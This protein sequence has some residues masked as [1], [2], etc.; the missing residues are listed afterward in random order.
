MCRCKGWPVGTLDIIFVRSLSQ[1]SF[2]A[3]PCAMHGLIHVMCMYTHIWMGLE[4]CSLACPMLQLLRA[5][6]KPCVELAVET[7]AVRS[8]GQHPA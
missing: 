4:A 8:M 2:A 7:D 5:L 6:C 1:M 3:R